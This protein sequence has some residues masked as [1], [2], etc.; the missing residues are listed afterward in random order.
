MQVR[1]LVQHDLKNSTPT[2]RQ[3]NDFSPEDLFVS[4]R[5]LSSFSILKSEFFLSHKC[6]FSLTTSLI[7]RRESK[8]KIFTHIIQRGTSLQL[9]LS[10]DFCFFFFFF[11]HQF[12]NFREN[13]LRSWADPPGYFLSGT[14][15][16]YLAERV[17][18]FCAVARQRKQ[19]ERRGREMTTRCRESAKSKQL[20]ALRGNSETFSTLTFAYLP[21][22]I[23]S[24]LSKSRQ[25]F[26]TRATHS[27][28]RQS[29]LFQ[30]SIEQTWKIFERNIRW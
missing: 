17:C 12:A 20:P 28:F 15:R 23:L 16:A 24:P 25:Q 27:R 18:N 1:T 3:L 6:T 22:R 14:D 5:D 9:I 10:F 7:L 19:T 21:W 29:D 13:N 4:L 2:T 26:E 11:W 30:K 8:M